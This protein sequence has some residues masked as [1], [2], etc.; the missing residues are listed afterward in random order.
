MYFNPGRK[1]GLRKGE[2]ELKRSQRMAQQTSF[3][4]QQGQS[5]AQEHGKR[6]TRYSFRY[7][8]KALRF[9]GLLSY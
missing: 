4:V 6:G 7:S 9:G 5:R 1:K 8:T 3:A 2:Y